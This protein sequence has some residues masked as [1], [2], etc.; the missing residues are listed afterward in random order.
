[1]WYSLPV[2]EAFWSVASPDQFP[3]SQESCSFMLVSCGLIPLALLR[4]NA[5]DGYSTAPGLIRGKGMLWHKVTSAEEWTPGV[6][7]QP[8]WQS[9][10]N[11]TY[12]KGACDSV[13][14]SSHP[15]PATGEGLS[16]L[17]LLLRRRSDS[18]E[19]RSER[20]VKCSL[21]GH[22]LSMMPFSVPW[23]CM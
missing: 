11:P 22:W 21:L 9:K 10:H 15:D 20:I 18:I 8:G 17:P 6:N 7:S 13:R 1:M 4:Q 23:C 19:T 5:T 16:D 3:R 12:P 14:G 2:R